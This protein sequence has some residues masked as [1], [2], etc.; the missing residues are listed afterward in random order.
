[1]FASATA[2]CSHAVSGAETKG[3]DE[4]YGGGTVSTFWTTSSIP[5]CF[6]SGDQAHRDATRSILADNWSRVAKVPFT[7]FGTC[8]SSNPRNTIRVT[9]ENDTYGYTANFGPTSAG[10]TNVTLISNGTAQHFRYEVLHEFGHA[11]GFR[12][13]QQRPDN[14]DK[15]GNTIY[16]GERDGGPSAPGGIYY[17]P[18]DNLSIMS[19][20]AYWATHLSA[21]DVFGLRQV[22]GSTAAI[23]CQ[24][25]S[26]TYGIDANGSF[27]FAPRSV[28]AQWRSMSC[29]TSP[30]SADSCQKAS[31]LYGIEANGSSGFAPSEVQSWWASN[32]CNTK[33][34]SSIELCQRASETYGIVANRTVGTAPSFGTAPSSVQAWWSSESC[35]AVPRYQDTCQR[36]SD[37]YGINENTPGWAPNEVQSYWRTNDCDTTPVVSSAC[38]LLSDNYGLS[39]SLSTGAAPAAARS[40]WKSNSCSTSPSSTN[41]CQRAADL[42]G[43]VPDVTWGWAPLEV[44]TW[45]TTAGCSSKPT[46]MDTCQTAADR[47]GIIANYT[48]GAA[49]AAVQTWWNAAGCNTRSKDVLPIPG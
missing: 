24:A 10:S 49:P 2:A 46:V 18:A 33:P 38:Q 27:G 8:S 7:G 28:Q 1:V 6:A 47:F 13:D 17:G 42:Y 20:C 4:L 35:N 39:P 36:M 3:D 22:Y 12:H 34:R 9:F 30:S 32:A 29:S 14:W 44:Q 16:C 5:V 43:I 41:T 31:D 37:L 40:Y 25:L 19:Y 48:L 23:T 21:T 11:I 45:W 15:Q 26:D